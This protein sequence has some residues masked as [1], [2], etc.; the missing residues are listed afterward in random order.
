MGQKV[1]KNTPLMSVDFAQGESNSISG[2]STAHQRLCIAGSVEGNTQCDQ[3]GMKGG[4]ADTGDRQI[5]LPKGHGAESNLFK[6]CASR[7]PCL[8]G[9]H[10][11][12][13]PATG[14]RCA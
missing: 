11:P 10:A 2:T 6:R 1:K 7:T 14:S 8:P 9:R 12:R 3:A 5:F 13:P 4:G